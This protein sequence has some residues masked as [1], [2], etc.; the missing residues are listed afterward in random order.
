MAKRFD[1]DLRE[2]KNQDCR[3]RCNKKDRSRFAEDELCRIAVSSLD[4]RAVRCVGEWSERKIAYLV[5]YFNIFSVGMKDLW[6]G[7]N[8]VEI[9]SGPGRCVVRSSGRE[10]D[11]TCTAIINQEAFGN[12]RKAVF[13]DKSADVVDTLNS[14]IRDLSRDNTARAIVGDYSDVDSI[15][16]ILSDLPNRCLTLV[17]L[18]PTDCS[19]PFATIRDITGTLSNV[20]LII[21]ISIGHDVN[22]NVKAAIF[23][24]NDLPSRT[25]YIAF[26]GGDT[27][28][29]SE[30]VAQFALT[31]DDQQL[32]QIFRE[33]YKSSLQSL[34]YMYFGIERVKHYYDLLFASK[35]PRGLDF[36]RKANRI[37][38]DR[39]YKLDFEQD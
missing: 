8:Y 32:R 7:I 23:G 19:F 25:K 37:T 9:G 17:F 11:G 31:H 24:T 34:G 2:T 29:N 1:I 36:W 5:K 27:Y 39:Q 22:R 30:E 16:R 15:S 4:A 13:I 21:N 6:D 14:R 20:D 28:F 33:E 12:I 18:D 35:H 26:L 3:T 38:P 10:I